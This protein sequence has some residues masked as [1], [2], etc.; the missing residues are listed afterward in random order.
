MIW[1]FN[2]GLGVCAL[3]I[4]ANWGSL[5]D[6]AFRKRSLSFA[7]PFLSGLLATLLIAMHPDVE[8]RAFWW[9]PLLLDPSIAFALSATAVMALVRR[10][11]A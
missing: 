4:V 1:V 8:V 5:I 7:P 2:F 6:A 3:L 9:L 11:R 10:L